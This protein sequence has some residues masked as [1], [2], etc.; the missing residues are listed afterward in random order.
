[1]SRI[2]GI[3]D[4][5]IYAD[6]M[7]KFVSEGHNVFIVSPIERRFK[8]PSFVIEGDGYKILRVKTLNLQKT[9]VVE[10]GV[11]Q[12]LLESQYAKGISKH[13]ADVDFD[14]ILYSTP[15]I[16]FNKVIEPYKKKGIRTYLMLKDIFP[17]NAVDLGMMKEG[18]FL[19]RMFRKK[20]EKLYELS[21]TIG[22]MSPANCEYVIRHNPEVDP[23]KVEV[24]PNSV[25][26]I[27]LPSI[28][29]EERDGI[30]KKYNIPTDKTLFIYGGNLGKPQG[31]DFLIE[32]IA[33]NEKR[34]NSFI[35]V[36]GDGTEY[37][38]IARW[39][40]ENRPKNACLHARLPKADYDTLVRV[41]DVGL[42]FLDPRF[43]IPNYPSRLLSYLENGMPIL[44]A[45]DTNTDIGKIAE[46]NGYGFWCES[47]DL[48][49]F[50]GFI[51]QL[52]SNREAIR[53]MGRAGKDFLM[54]NYIVDNTANSI[55]KLKN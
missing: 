51:E 27:D 43:T 38:R 55:L 9:N 13:F 30:L 4:R 11:A 44:A 32:V 17:Q 26:L 5:G 16:T 34:S 15:P 40:E 42:I 45:T 50:M 23:A 33:A 31:I 8:K 53:T 22:C 14:L 18:S 49:K 3:N 48:S 52:S 12:L 54:K 19:H 2:D 24:C 29:K 39:F 21:D 6:L 10:K 41:H 37:G 47:G 20:E 46:E 25:E 35:T 7:R 1:M 28:S 36:V